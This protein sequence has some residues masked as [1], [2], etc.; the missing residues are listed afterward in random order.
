MSTL[1]FFE[2]AGMQRLESQSLNLLIIVYSEVKS[3]EG[4]ASE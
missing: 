1:T 2:V 3:N 4:I